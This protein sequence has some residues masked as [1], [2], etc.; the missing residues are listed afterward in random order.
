MADR[1]I[2]IAATTALALGLAACGGGNA[3]P[4]T[5]STAQS[6]T[7]TSP[8]TPARP[9]VLDLNGVRP[10]ELLTKEQQAPFGIDRPIQAGHSDTLNA[11]DCNFINDKEK[12]GF[13]LTAMTKEGVARFAPGQ[14]TGEVRQ[15]AVS[16]Y[17]AYEVWTPSMPGNEFCT[18]Q[19]DVADGQVLRSHYSES[20]RKQPLGRAELCKRA[21]QVAEAAVATLSK[22]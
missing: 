9:K 8:A 13:V 17:F 10:C 3:G 11:D 21:A 22:K 12:V 18:V 19:V 16:G 15:V 20:N 14:V 7:S 2:L 4:G 5:S 6:S 1:R